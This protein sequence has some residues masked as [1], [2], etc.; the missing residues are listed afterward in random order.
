MAEME[1][2]MGNTETVFVGYD[3]NG[4]PIF[5]TIEYASGSYEDGPCR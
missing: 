5:E 4:T 3:E 1:D 2:I